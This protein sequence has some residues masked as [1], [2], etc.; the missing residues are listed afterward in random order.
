MQSL[1]HGTAASCSTDSF[2]LTNGTLLVCLLCCRLKH[3]SIS[4]SFIWH[5][6]TTYTISKDLAIAVHNGTTI[7]IHSFPAIHS[8][9]LSVRFSVQLSCRHL[10]P[11]RWINFEMVMLFRVLNTDQ[12]VNFS[13]LTVN[14]RQSCL[15]F[16]IEYNRRFSLVSLFLSQLHLLQHLHAYIHYTYIHIMYTHAHT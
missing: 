15:Q 16:R 12:R 8:F 6:Q 5:L 14:Q 3:W 1:E 13:L 10:K 2:R 11:M 7:P 4:L 9:H